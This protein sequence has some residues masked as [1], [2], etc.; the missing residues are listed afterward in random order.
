MTMRGIFPSPMHWHRQCYCP[1]RRR[2]SC[3]LGLSCLTGSSRW[4]GFVVVGAFG[5]CRVGV[6]RVQGPHW[7]IVGLGQRG[8]PA[9]QVVVVT[10]A[11]LAFCSRV[12]RWQ[13]RWWFSRRVV[14]CFHSCQGLVEG[15]DNAHVLAILS[16]PVCWHGGRWLVVG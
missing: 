2:R 15:C 1:I 11:R 13:R 6:A 5:G 9:R 12:C 14:L 8:D 16:H 7:L 3:S 4:V 10:P